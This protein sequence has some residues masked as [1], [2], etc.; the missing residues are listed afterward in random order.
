MLF[1]EVQPGGGQPIPIAV[2]LVWE[3]A[4]VVKI[5]IIGMGGI[6]SAADAVEFFIAGASAVAVGTANF[7]EPT[8]AL[9][10]AAGSASDLALHALTPQRS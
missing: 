6:Y 3:A 2:R 1:G 4:K 9:T 5:P 7:L 10:V 8:T